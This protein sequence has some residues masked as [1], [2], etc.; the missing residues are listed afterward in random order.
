V[1]R[2][3]EDQSIEQVADLLGCSIG[4]VKSQTAHGLQRLREVLGDRFTSYVGEAR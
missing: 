3:W 4:T 1:L 2:Y